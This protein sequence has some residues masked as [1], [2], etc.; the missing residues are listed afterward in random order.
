MAETDDLRATLNELRVIEAIKRLKAI[1]CRLV[2]GSRWDELAE[3]FTEDA[4]CDYGF[5]GR[6]EGRR[7]TLESTTRTEGRT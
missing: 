2:D 3:L 5:F 7:Q 1:Y 6:Y 4:V